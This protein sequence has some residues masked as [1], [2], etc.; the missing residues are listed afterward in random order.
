MNN[1]QLLKFFVSLCP[2]FEKYW[3][4][5]GDIY[6]E[7]DDYTIYGVCSVFSWYYRDNYSEFSHRNLN[8][9]FQKIEEVVSDENELDA[10]NA[11]CT[12]FLENIAGEEVGRFSR[13]FMGSKSKEFFDY[14]N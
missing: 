2:E 13:E 5:E 10:A 14:W 11:L 6:R 3:D 12:C 9:L 1:E 4:S 7:G 8:T